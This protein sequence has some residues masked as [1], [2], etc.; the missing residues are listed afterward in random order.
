MDM[1]PSLK[2]PKLRS[3]VKFFGCHVQKQ[4]HRFTSKLNYCNLECVN[5]IRDTV[6]STRRWDAG[7]AVGVQKKKTNKSKM[8]RNHA[9]LFARLG[10]SQKLP[11]LVRTFQGRFN[12]SNKFKNAKNLLQQ[13]WP[14][15]YEN[16]VIFVQKWIL[17]LRPLNFEILYRLLSRNSESY[18]SCMWTSYVTLIPSP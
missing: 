11:N 3:C 18:V 7:K 5:K 2:T 16:Q 8:R 1:F 12:P 6:Q 13:N 14:F 10:C 9:K 17:I 15:S 4:C